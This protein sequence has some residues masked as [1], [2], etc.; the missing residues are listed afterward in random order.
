M[1]ERR[2]AVLCG[3][4]VLISGYQLEVENV[5]LI[6]VNILN[7]SPSPI[8]KKIMY[9]IQ[10][11]TYYWIITWIISSFF[12]ANA[13]KLMKSEQWKLE[14]FI[15]FFHHQSD[16]FQRIFTL[17]LTVHSRKFRVHLR[18]S[19]VNWWIT[20]INRNESTK[21]NEIFHRI[22]SWLV[23]TC[24]FA[25]SRGVLKPETCWTKVNWRLRWWIGI[26]AN[27]TSLWCWKIF[28]GIKSNEN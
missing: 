4:R 15:G 3:L 5:K 14:K 2:S 24:N 10:I 1:N 23:T 26:H 22:V 21:I 8:E 25:D 13:F 9:Q 28:F 16:N 27:L 11:S 12:S 7:F 6:C 20:L 19:L 18:K 17:Q